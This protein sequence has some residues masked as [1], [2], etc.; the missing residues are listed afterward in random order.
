VA[1]GAAL[2]RLLAK[3]NGRVARSAVQ[4]GDQEFNA[5]GR[6]LYDTLAQLTSFMRYKRS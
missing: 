3:P 4:L 5:D 2:A 1:T 6:A